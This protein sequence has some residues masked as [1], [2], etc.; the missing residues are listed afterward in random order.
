MV[1]ELFLQGIATAMNMI[2]TEC[3]TLVAYKNVKSVK[4]KNTQ[5]QEII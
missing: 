3:H 1:S 5:K 4:T 2:L